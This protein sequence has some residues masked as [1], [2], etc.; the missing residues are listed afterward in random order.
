MQQW[1]KAFEEKRAPTSLARL[2]LT[3]GG[4]PRSK[5]WVRGCFAPHKTSQV[6]HRQDRLKVLLIRSSS[7]VAS[8]TSATEAGTSP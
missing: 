2:L 7:G 1:E 3:M 8:V 6:V 4:P 5:G